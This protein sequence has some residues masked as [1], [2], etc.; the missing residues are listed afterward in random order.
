MIYTQSSIAAALAYA[1]HSTAKTQRSRADGILLTQ[2]PREPKDQ[3]ATA[4]SAK[5][6]EFEATTRPQNPPHAAALMLSF[7]G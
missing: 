4:N 3:T 1:A 7:A 2:R 6:Q 5:S